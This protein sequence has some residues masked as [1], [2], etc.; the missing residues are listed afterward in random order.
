MPEPC[1]FFTDYLSLYTVQ[2]FKAQLSLI[3]DEA[4]ALSTSEKRAQVLKLGTQEMRSI[5][6]VTTCE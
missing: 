1:F 6:L 5:Q 4:G 2:L 3:L